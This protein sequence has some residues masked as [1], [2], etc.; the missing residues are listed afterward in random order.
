MT[1][2]VSSTDETVEPTWA[3]THSTSYATTAT[4]PVT[5]PPVALPVA[6]TSAPALN[7]PTW[8]GRKTAIAAALAIGISSVGAAGA[9]VAVPTGSFQG[10]QAQFQR[11]GFSPGRGGPGGA[12]GRFQQPP[13]GQLQ[14]GPNG[15][16]SQLPGSTSQDPST[17]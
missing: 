6:A 14:Q 3:T 2:P 16:T 8:S 15:T 5:E 1:S 7:P 17:T 12:R 9:A 13:G 10:D 4:A 11:G